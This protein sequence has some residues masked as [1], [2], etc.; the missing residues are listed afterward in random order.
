MEHLFTSKHK[1][2]TTHWCFLFMF[3]FQRIEIVLWTQNL[4][5]HDDECGF[6]ILETSHEIKCNHAVAFFIWFLFAKIQHRWNYE[7]F[8]HLTFNNRFLISILEAEID[9]SYIAPFEGLIVVE[10]KRAWNMHKSIQCQF[11]HSHILFGIKIFL[12]HCKPNR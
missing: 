7:H 2:K 8:T 12:C 5:R 1:F 9:A 4:K 10:W 6:V 11:I 3:P